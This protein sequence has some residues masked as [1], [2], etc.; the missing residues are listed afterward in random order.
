MI[1]GGAADGRHGDPRGSCSPRARERRADPLSV[2]PATIRGVVEERAHPPGWRP[3]PDDDEPP[4]EP[5]DV[6]D[7]LLAQLELHRERLVRK[8]DGLTDEQLRTPVLPSGWTALEL[9]VHLAAVE[10]R[11]LE[12]GF[13]AEPLPDPWRDQGPDGRWRAPDGATGASV[14][15]DLR[16]QWEVSR[17]VVAGVPLGARAALGGRFATPGE[18]PTLGWVLLHLL[19]ETARHVGH[20]DVVR[21]LLDGQVGE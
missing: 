1:P 4:R 13:R 21:E 20:L 19:Q 16:A 6:R 8:V 15:A 2:A 9:L 7:V 3:G 14:V 17:D 11:W 12:W 18:A 5:D 10:R